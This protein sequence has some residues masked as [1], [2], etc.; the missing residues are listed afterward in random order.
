M[1][2]PPD[3]QPTPADEAGRSHQWTCPL[4]DLLQIA[5]Q[6]GNPVR[7]LTKSRATHDGWPVDVRQNGVILRRH[8]GSLVAVAHRAME[9]VR[10]LAGGG[11]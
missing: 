2:R 5:C 7:V 6:D 3:T 11:S 4:V 9:A 8:D 1:T 10:L